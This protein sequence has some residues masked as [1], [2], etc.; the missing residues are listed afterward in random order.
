MKKLHLILLLPLLL[1]SCDDDKTTEPSISCTIT[2]H[3]DG[4]VIMNN[5]GS[6][7]E[8]DVKAVESEVNK[9]EFYFDN[10]LLSTVL[11]EPYETW[12]YPKDI[13][14]GE[15][16]ITVVAMSD[17]G[18]QAK[19][20]VTVK[21]LV[22]LGVD[23]QGGVVIKLSEDKLHGTIASKFDLNGGNN[24]LYKYGV[25]NG[26]YQAY[27]MDDGLENTNRFEGKYDNNHAANACLRHEEGGYGDWYLP[28]YNELALFENYKT[29]LYI[30]ERTGNKYWSSTGSAENEKGAYVY[31]F[32][33]AV[34]NP[35][36]MQ[37][38]MHVRPC[39]RF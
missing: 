15:Y 22:D 39:R 3:A 1:W 10:K 29:K 16:K 9:V 36:D 4:D 7:I 24:G 19:D 30:P 27:S 11:S 18:K 13:Q 34:G 26:N 23:F 17:G 12:F 20:E 6:L 38:E 37:R 2:K 31:S 32:S 35:F 14:P 33:G 28:A 21:I 25:Y 8:V 5:S